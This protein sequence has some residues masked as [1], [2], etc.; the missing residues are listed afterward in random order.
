MYI[1]FLPA[2]VALVVIGFITL[3]DQFSFK[4]R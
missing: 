4:M 2:V 3:R 1:F